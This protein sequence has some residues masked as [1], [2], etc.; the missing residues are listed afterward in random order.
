M[1]KVSYNNNNIFFNHKTFPKYLSNVVKVWEY[2]ININ[3]REIIDIIEK[4]ENGNFSI[5]CHNPYEVFEFFCQYFN[6]IH[7]AGGVVRN[8]NEDMLFI[9]RLNKWD[10]PKGKVE[11]SESPEH[12]ALREV[13]EETGI[14]NLKIVKP[15]SNTYHIYK[16]NDKKIL[17]I[18]HWYEMY[19]NY[20]GQLTPQLIE[21]ITK[22]EWINK[23]DISEILEESYQT[24]KDLIEFH[25]F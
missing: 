3:F 4:H 8:D 7:A 23:D 14:K 2:D 16:L 22:V 1:I 19:S 24:I 18:G 25:Y 12:T 15:L 21:N 5:L 9:Y 13:K 11:K 20:K 6:V 17:K 10:L